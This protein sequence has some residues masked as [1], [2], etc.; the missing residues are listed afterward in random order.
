MAV[1]LGILLAGLF[2]AAFAFWAFGERFHV[3]RSTWAFFRES[4]PRLRTLHGYVYGRWTPRYI[5]TLLSLSGG[6]SERG[7]RISQ[8][9]ADRYHGK[10]L[11]PEQARAIV[12]I[13]AP[14][15]RKDL[16]QIV[17]FPVARGL[18][19]DAPPDVVLYECVCRHARATHREPTQVCMVIGK[20]M[21]DFVLAH[22]PGKARRIDAA[23]AVAVLEAE[24]ARG[25]V[26]S[27]WFKD[28]MLG[29]FYAICNCCSCCCGGLAA[30]RGGVRMVASSGFVAEIDRDL[31]VDC[32]DCASTCPFEALVRQDDRVERDW[33]RCMGCG[34]CESRCATGAIRLER[35]PRKGVPL[36]VRASA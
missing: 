21:S 12:E 33:E 15:E 27:A 8:W 36:D 28:A 29:R 10:V 20:P 32:G 5:A 1:A 22:Q 13:E 24:H 19:L 11:T 17:P 7:R 30:M 6:G 3:H 31:C 2:L 34:V 9:L 26:H 25:H 16:E 23:E 14:I 18:V 4:G 35:D